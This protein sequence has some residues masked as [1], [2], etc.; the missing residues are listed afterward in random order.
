[1]Y[2]YIGSATQDKSTR[3]TWRS[4]SD[5]PDSGGSSGL[6][7]RAVQVRQ[8]RRPQ[9][10]HHATHPC[11]RTP[12]VGEPKLFKTLVDRGEDILT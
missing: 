11:R 9:L 7:L 1:V 8:R 3:A 6:L 5:Q 12:G 10:G 2:K 4:P